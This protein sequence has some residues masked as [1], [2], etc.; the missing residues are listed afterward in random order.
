MGGRHVQTRAPSFPEVPTDAVLEVADNERWQVV[1]GDTDHWRLGI[2]SPPESSPEQCDEL[3]EHTCPEL[4]V[5]LSGHVTLVLADGK[6]G[7]RELVL[8]PEKPVLIST[9]HAGFC[10]NGPHTGKCLVVERDAFETEY[11]AV[12]HW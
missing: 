2:Y 3:E 5:L 10:P 6:G 11:R 7:T 9:P 8:E 4:F 1:C 12:E